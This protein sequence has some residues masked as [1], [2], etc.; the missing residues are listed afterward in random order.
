MRTCEF[1]SLDN[2][3]GRAPW[4]FN[5]F[6]FPPPPPPPLSPPS[7]PPRPPK[8][9]SLRASG[10]ATSYYT[11]WPYHGDGHG[12]APLEYPCKG[13]EKGDHSLKDVLMDAAVK[14][15]YP[16]PDDEKSGWELIVKTG[17]IHSTGGVAFGAHDGANFK[18][19]P[20]THW[21]LTLSRGARDKRPKPALHGP[22]RVSTSGLSVEVTATCKLDVEIRVEVAS[23]LFKKSTLWMC[24]EKKFA[25]DGAGAGAMVCTAG[26]GAGAGVSKAAAG[27]GAGAASAV[28]AAGACL[29][30]HD[31]DATEVLIPCGHV[32]YCKSC[33]R[34][35]THDHGHSCPICKAAFSLRI[36]APTSNCACG[37]RHDVVNNAMDTDCQHAAKL[38]SEC[39][40]MFQKH[41]IIDKEREVGQDA[42]C[43]Q[44]ALEKFECKIVQRQRVYY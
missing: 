22:L 21:L 13:A 27:A 43:A 23:A 12:K 36:T 8:H 30:C 41:G 9:Q 38:C 26:A 4:Q 1:H 39:I 40:A 32:P 28:A 11:L 31:S 10:M 25:S 16:Q 29:A 2:H 24:G 37:R 6:P 3:H 18:P 33:A 15:E 44:C 5:E 35:H 42:V 19:R 20:N 34:K 7:P 17:E 14:W